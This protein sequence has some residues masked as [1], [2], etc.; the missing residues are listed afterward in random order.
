[1][2]AAALAW[3]DLLPFAELDDLRSWLHE[4]GAFELRERGVRD[5]ADASAWP[6]I[7]DVLALVLGDPAEVIEGTGGY[8]V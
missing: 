2:T 5:V 3:L 6:V 7:A 8:W 4:R 1:M